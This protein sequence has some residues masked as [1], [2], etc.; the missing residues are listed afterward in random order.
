MTY[1]ITNELS[2]NFFFWLMKE[3]M[4]MHL[5]FPWNFMQPG[6]SGYP[7]LREA[8]PSKRIIAE[9]GIAAQIKTKNRSKKL[10]R[11]NLFMVPSGE[12]RTPGSGPN[13]RR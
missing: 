12:S 5:I 8:M 3:T 11:L 13:N 9:D 7:F 4:W 1:F 6:L 2:L 10:K